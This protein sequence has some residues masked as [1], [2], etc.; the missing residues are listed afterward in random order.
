MLCKLQN[1]NRPLFQTEFFLLILLS[2]AT[3]GGW[4]PGARAQDS[5][6]APAVGTISGTVLL[7][8]NNRP[9]SQVAVTLR[10]KPAGV[11]RCVLTDTEGHFEV[12]GLPLATY[13]VV[14]DEPGY[15][16]AQSTVR[17]EGSSSE[18]VLYL[19]TP[20]AAQSPRT[21]YS[22][23]VRELRM[24]DKARSEYQ[25]GLACLR[26]NEF[27]ESVAHL[28]KA[29]QDFPEFYEALYHIG[30]AQTK[31]GHREEAMSAFQKAID[32]SGGKFAAAQFGIG[33]LHYLQGKSEEAVTAVRRGLE[34]DQNSA[35]GYLILALAQLQ[36]N[37]L[38]DAEK[39]VQEALLRNPNFAQ[40][41]LVLANVYG[42]RHEYHAQLQGLDAYLKMQPNSADSLGVRQTRRA[43]QSLLADARP[44]N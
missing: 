36:M 35:D 37:R 11:S 20:S 23:S 16:P 34:M 33:Y 8:V 31:Q 42:R 44:E 39:S 5:G 32:L 2:M 25:K 22:V 18:L 7:K 6:S 12:Q 4:P 21:N 19:N 24:P 10:S 26:K 13:D 17:L 27:A 1:L 40:A 29:A 43:V 41:Y 3:I 9:A 14:V 28:T 15:E 30:V 38:D